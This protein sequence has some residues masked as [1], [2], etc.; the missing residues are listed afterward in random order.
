VNDDVVPTQADPTIFDRFPLERSESARHS[1]AR[2][3]RAYAKGKIDRE[4]YRD[5][6]YGLSAYMS[7]LKL[8]RDDDLEARIGAL[9][10][11]INGNER[12]GFSR[13]RA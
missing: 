2:V 1:F 11:R 10:E 5:L 9:E 3:I 13:L 8:A 4:T 12:P 6:V 7:A